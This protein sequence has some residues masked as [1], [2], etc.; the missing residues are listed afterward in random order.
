LKGGSGS[1]WDAAMPS[2]GAVTAGVIVT[3]A[4]QIQWGGSDARQ[5]GGADVMELGK[6]VGSGIFLVS[7]M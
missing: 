2:V 5:I 3:G 6:V 1:W 7:A 4:M